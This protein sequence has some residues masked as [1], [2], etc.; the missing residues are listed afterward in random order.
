MK[1][2]ILLIFLII[3]VLVSLSAV[4]A[5]DSVDDIISADG[6]AS[7][8]YVTGGGMTPISEPKPALLQQ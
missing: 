5:T 7:D 8:I 4:S 6:D 3:F 2:K 1:N